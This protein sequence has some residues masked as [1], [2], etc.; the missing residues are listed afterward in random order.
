VLHFERQRAIK[1][2]LQK[3]LT[4]RVRQLVTGLREDSVVTE[5]TTVYAVLHKNF[6]EKYEICPKRYRRFKVNLFENIGL[7]DPWP[8]D[9]DSGAA[10]L[11]NIPQ[12]NDHQVYPDF[13]YIEG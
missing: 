11:L 3:C 10:K 4:S 1:V 2:E 13:K 5:E 6:Y 12:D 8:D 7:A 9:V